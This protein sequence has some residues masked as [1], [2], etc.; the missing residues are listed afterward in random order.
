LAQNGQPGA[1]GSE[2]RQ[3]S[4]IVKKMPPNADY[5]LFVSMDLKSSHSV[6][7]TIA[8]VPNFGIKALIPAHIRG[9]STNPREVL[10]RM[11]HF[12]RSR[13]NMQ[14]KVV[15]EWKD[16]TNKAK[17]KYSKNIEE[18]G[19]LKILLISGG[20][21]WKDVTPDFDSL[22]NLEQ[23]VKD[24]NK[25]KPKQA[26]KASSKQVAPRTPPLRTRSSQQPPGT[27]AGSTSAVAGAAVVSEPPAALASNNENVDPQVQV[28]SASMRLVPEK[29]TGGHCGL[30]SAPGL[31]NAAAEE[32]KKRSRSDVKRRIGA[33]AE[34][35]DQQGDAT[36]NAA[37][38][39]AMVSFAKAADTVHYP[40]RTKGQPRRCLLMLDV[41]QVEEKT[42][43]G[44]STGQGRAMRKKTCVTFTG[45]T[46]KKEIAEILQHVYLSLKHDNDKNPTHE[47]Q[48]NYR[49]PQTKLVSTTVA[50]EIQ[51]SK[52]SR[53]QP[54]KKPKTGQE[55]VSE[56]FARLA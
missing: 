22:W 34:T 51:N 47:S 35:L 41:N 38:Q 5:M 30:A 21:N 46:D 55:C 33:H 53:A 26:P 8:L 29:L 11:R 48:I 10:H 18:L 52:L 39:T 32:A 17:S 4:T 56:Q 23:A 6:M 40:N 50:R 31:R 3:S 36:S 45:G 43:S 13:Q 25:S 19:A 12:R 16:M 27:T 44:G 1:N 7:N 28:L 49:D 42:A 24:T 37:I 9:C 15:Q 14:D 20:A 2:G 54:L